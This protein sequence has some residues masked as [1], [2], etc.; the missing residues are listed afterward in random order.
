VQVQDPVHPEREA[1]RVALR[2]LALSVS[3]SAHKSFR[4][5]GRTYSHIMDPRTGRPVEGILGVAVL[6]R[7][8]TAGDALDNALFVEGIEAARRHLRRLPDTRAFFLLPDGPDGFQ[9][10]RLGD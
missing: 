4:V 5:G 2:D 10:V 6:S 9:V 7:S 8:A 3:G 1:F